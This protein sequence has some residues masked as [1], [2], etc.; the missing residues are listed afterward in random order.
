MNN[1][2]NAYV[3]HVKSNVCGVDWSRLALTEYSLAA[4][5][6]KIVA[7]YV[8][9]FIETLQMNGLL[10]NQ[11]ILIGHSM[12]AHIAGIVG[13]QLNGEVAKIIGTE[14]NLNFAINSV[15]C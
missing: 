5:N 13:N 6:T 4:N 10:L 12:G 14:I 1:T 3:E 11:V 15:V 7:K 9:K 2:I 8:I